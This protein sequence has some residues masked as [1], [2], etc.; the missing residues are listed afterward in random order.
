MD[1]EKGEW[2]N[3]QNKE[4]SYQYSTTNIFQVIKIEK[5]KIGRAC[6][7]CGVEERRI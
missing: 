2:R 6:S 4:L 5:N 1:R 7:A 3:L